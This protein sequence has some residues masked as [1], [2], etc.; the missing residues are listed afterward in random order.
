MV[1]QFVLSD[2]MTAT[3]KKRKLTTTPKDCS[4]DRSK[5]KSMATGESS[6]IPLVDATRILMVITKNR[7]SISIP[8]LRP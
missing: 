7:L 8:G 4:L 1:S 2:D 6:N 3:N 5:R